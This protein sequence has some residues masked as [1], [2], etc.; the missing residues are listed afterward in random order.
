[1]IVSCFASSLVNDVHRGRNPPIPPICSI[2][3]CF[4][5]WHEYGCLRLNL[6]ANNCEMLSS[7]M[8]MSCVCV[9]HQVSI[10]PILLYFL[11]VPW[12]PGNNVCSPYQNFSL[13]LA[14][15]PH[16]SYTLCV[17]DNTIIKVIHKHIRTMLLPLVAW[18]FLK[19][20]WTFGISLPVFSP[21]PSNGSSRYPCVHDCSSTVVSA[22]LPCHMSQ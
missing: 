22:L 7:C 21:D 2:I 6:L 17:P 9:K 14:F 10:I 3:A 19:L 5:N 8:S 1:M 15:P 13:Q 11:Q 16:N 20:F 18:G 4:L 12:P